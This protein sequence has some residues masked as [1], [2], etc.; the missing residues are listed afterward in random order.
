MIDFN[1]AFENCSINRCVE[2]THSNEFYVAE[3]EDKR[4]YIIYNPYP[5][6][7]NFSVLNPLG[8][9]IT[10]VAVDNCIYCSNDSE[11][12][13]FVIYDDDVFCFVELKRAFDPKLIVEKRD[14]AINQLIETITAFNYIIDYGGRRVE[15]YPCVGYNKCV[16][17]CSASNLA[18]IKLFE[19]RF[20]VDL[21]DGNQREFKYY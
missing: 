4:C 8:K 2:S 7:P 9:E 21:C 12:C 5:D 14:K 10:M 6:Y 1:L 3:K 11:R 16:P 18:H 20:Q 15:A 19:D 17:Q 13:D